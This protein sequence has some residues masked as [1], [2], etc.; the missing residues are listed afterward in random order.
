MDG[1]WEAP[2]IDNPEYKGEWSAKKIDN[3]EYKGE[4]VHPEIAN[5]EYVH[6]DAVYDYADFGAVGID[7]W[8]VK[9]GTIFDSIII[10]TD[11]AEAEA[12]VA[13]FKTLSEGEKAM[14][15]EA[16]DKAAAEAEAKK[17]EEE[18]A[19]KKEEEEAAAE[20]GDEE[21]GDEDE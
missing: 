14:K 3:P 15:K 8:Q 12:G 18:E 2:T 19:K 7:I 17:K 11:A 20:S 4:W 13:A 16:D 10:T 1:E 6:D 5:P 9:S 21:S